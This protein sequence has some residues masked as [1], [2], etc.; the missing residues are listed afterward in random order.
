MIF[1]FPL[2]LEKH[3]SH[4]SLPVTT[5]TLNLGFKNIHAILSQWARVIGPLFLTSF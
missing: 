2:F 3:F 4:S 1:F 5:V